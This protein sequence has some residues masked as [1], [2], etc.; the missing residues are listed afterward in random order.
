MIVGD[1]MEPLALLN[2]ASDRLD[3]DWD[4]LLTDAQKLA[5]RNVAG[6]IGNFAKS[7]PRKKHSL[8]FLGL[9]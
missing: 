2:H 1:I 4:G 3:G 6:L 5:E 9:R 7:Q 8:I